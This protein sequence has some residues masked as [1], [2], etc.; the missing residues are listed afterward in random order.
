M[1]EEVYDEL[2]SAFVFFHVRCLFIIK[3]AA[4]KLSIFGI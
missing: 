3:K 4:K 2:L 1:F